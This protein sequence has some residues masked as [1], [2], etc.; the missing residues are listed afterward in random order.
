MS[1]KKRTGGNPARAGEVEDARE[2]RRAKAAALRQRE[3]ARERSRR[4]LLVSIAVVVV[5]AL[6]AVVFVVIDR[7][8]QDDVPLAAQ[9]VPPSA[10]GNGAGLV[11]AGTPAAGAPTVDV[12]LDYQCPYC[13][14]FEAAAGD[15]VVELASSGQATVVVHTL[16]FLDGNLG[17]DSSQRAAEAAAAADAQGRFAEY[18]QVV[19]ANQPEQEGTGYTDAQLRDFAEQAGVPDLEAWQAAVDGH[20]YRDYVTSI[21]DSQQEAGVQGTPTVTVTPEGGEKSEIP[22]EQLLGAD[23][24][25]ALQQAVA[26]AT[27]AATP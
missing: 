7:S 14:R 20:A 1:S 26:A 24:V 17:N 21:A 12:W 25:G 9:A 10:S 18:N 2:A 5:L 15:A 19:F 27:P 16:T 22:I 6:A 23:P 11:L 8:R 13:A 4:V 3:L